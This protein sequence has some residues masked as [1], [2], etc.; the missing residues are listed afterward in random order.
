MRRIRKLAKLVYDRLKHLPWRT[1]HA[2]GTYQHGRIDSPEVMVN[3]RE[4][5]LQIENHD[6]FVK[7]VVR[8][9]GQVIYPG[10]KYLRW[11]PWAWE[12]RV[13]RRVI[14]KDQYNG[15]E[16]VPCDS[17]IE[18]DIAALTPPKPDRSRRGR[19]T[20]YKD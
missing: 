12:R 14:Q 10:G 11:W 8:I 1:I 16:I 18:D 7:V 3:D 17:V 9:G 5:D 13:Y 20:V 19:L 4:Y 15:I 6:L 2:H